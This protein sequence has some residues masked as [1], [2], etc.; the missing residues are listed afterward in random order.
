MVTLS[1]HQRL[2]TCGARRVR[3]FELDGA[4]HLAIPQL[5]EDI[6]EQEPH[7]NGGNSDVDLLIYRWSNGG[8]EEVERLAVP[9]GEDAEFFS[10]G[11]EQFLA[12]ASVRTGSGPYELDT[13]STIFRRDAGRWVSFQ[14][15]PAFAAKQWHYFHVD[16]RHLLALAAGVGIPGAQPRYCRQSRIFEWREGKFVEFQRL[17]GHW[18]Y[19][20]ADFA[21]GAEHYL[22]YADHGSA[23]ILYRWSGNQFV[24]EQSFA[25]QGGRAFT[26][27]QA[28][29]A[30]W[31]AFANIL[32]DSTLYRWDHGRFVA[33]QGLAGAGGR[34]FALIRA[35]SDL[36]V[37][38]VRF[39]EGKPEAPR[40]DLRSHL[41]RWQRG[42][43]QSVCDFATFGA[44]DAAA[45]RADGLDFLAVSNS[46]SID[47]RFRQDTIVYRLSW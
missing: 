20:W 38:L 3:T 1:P 13:L 12:T 41:Y 6:P 43:L 27:F 5:A 22:A 25:G 45:F 47:R 24:A 42:R 9:G 39:I 33:H 36:Y 44:T 30:S 15:V 10:I 11:S 7:M 35:A 32:G 46:L 28:D 4:L 18:G 26:F 2:H 17:E 34:E 8:F 14:Q 21:I 31:L 29:G 16:G 23:S 37:V 19:G 40:T